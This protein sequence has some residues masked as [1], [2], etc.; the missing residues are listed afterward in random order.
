[1]SEHNATIQWQRGAVDDFVGQRYSRKHTWHF[2]GGAV[3]PGSSSPQVVRLPFSDPSAVDPEEAFVAALS[4]CHMLWFLDFASRAGLPI[5]SYCDAAVG[6]LAPDADGK[7]AM[8]VVTLRPVV[9]LGA[10]LRGDF[11]EL[12]RL[13]HQAHAACFL[14]NSVKTEVRCEPSF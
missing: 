4:S 2:D 11:A 12:Q 7:M 10:N 14:A 6:T 9:Q 8:S 13:H 1:M 5:D 3:V